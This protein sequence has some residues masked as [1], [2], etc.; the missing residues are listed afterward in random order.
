[1]AERMWKQPYFFFSLTFIY[2]VYV[3]MYVHAHVCQSTHVEVR[4]QLESVLL[5]RGF[6]RSK[7]AARAFAHEV[8]SAAATFSASL[9][10]AIYSKKERNQARQAKMTDRQTDR[11]PLTLNP[12][13]RG[14]DLD[15]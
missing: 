4:G 12:N 3:C 11:L 15:S 1:M 8:I 9:S 14:W 13:S 2:F 7:P 5:P 6:W 10:G